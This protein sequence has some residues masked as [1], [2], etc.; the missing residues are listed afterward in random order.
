MSR[1][2]AP[3]PASVDGTLPGFN[4][5]PYALMVIIGGAFAFAAFVAVTMIRQRV[6]LVPAE[7]YER[8]LMHNE[9]M[10]RERR[11]RALQPPLEVRLT[12]E[13]DLV[14]TFPGVGELDGHIRL[15]RPSDGTR[16]QVFPVQ[17]DAEGRQL[18]PAAALVPGLWQ[19]QIEWTW[20]GEAYEVTEKIVLP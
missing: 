7:H 15:Y 6:D 4:P 1:D 19:V 5:W 14:V 8:D 17:P 20:D 13:R 11:G 16:D 10:A 2:A 12:P 18:V 9:R 3:A